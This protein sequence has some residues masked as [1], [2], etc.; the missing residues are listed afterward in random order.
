MAN[1]SLSSRVYGE[2]LHRLLSGALAPG[3]VFNRRQI[4]AELGVSVAPVLEAMLELEAEGLIES[5]PRQGTRVRQLT[6]DDLRGQLIVRE[7]L[8]CQAARLCCGQP[9]RRH[10]DRLLRLAEALDESDLRSA[11]HLKQEL[12][13]HHLLVSLANV[14]ALTDSFERVMKLG[15]LYAIQVL[16][17]D[18]QAAPRASHIELVH[19]L[20]TDD[21]DAA[22]L[23]MRTHA[24]SGKEALFASE[25]S[26]VR[27]SATLPLLPTWLKL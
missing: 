19:A 13:F 15:L 8:E 14:P 6:V 2:I 17:P 24:R 12:R 4:A 25:S 9:V 18:Q 22:E 10:R 20:S 21:P 3:Q 11:R 7:A 23:A 27:G 26:E 16:H 1:N 5:V